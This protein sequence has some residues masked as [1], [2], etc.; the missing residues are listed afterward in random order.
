MSR[1]AS[2][3]SHPS[4]TQ[5][6]R[7]G[8]I[9]WRTSALRSNPTWPATRRMRWSPS[10]TFLNTSSRSTSGTRRR[11]PG[12]W[13]GSPAGSSGSAHN[14]MTNC[15]GRPLRRHSR[16]ALLGVSW[17]HARDSSSASL[18]KKELAALSKGGHP[19]PPG[20][21][22]LAPSEI[23]ALLMRSPSLLRPA[24]TATAP[25]DVSDPMQAFVRAFHGI[26]PLHVRLAAVGNQAW[27]TWEMMESTKSGGPP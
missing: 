1:R 12:T 20:E 13:P 17:S 18:L 24:R 21:V 19:P 15:R 16:K 2:S 7:Q 3:R 8:W 22:V 6:P 25:R 23:A 10:R 27:G 5:G 14:P 26:P 11:R 9:S 4:L